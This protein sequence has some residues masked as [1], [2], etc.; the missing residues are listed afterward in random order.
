MGVFYLQSFEAANLAH[1]ILYTSSEWVIF[2]YLFFFILFFGLFAFFFFLLLFLFSL[3]L[4]FKS[5]SYFSILYSCMSSM[6]SLFLIIKLVSLFYIEKDPLTL[7]AVVSFASEYSFSSSGTK[8]F[9]VWVSK[10][11]FCISISKLGNSENVDPR[12]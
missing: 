10:L 2:C 3:T 4:F 12:S 11:A 7:Y 5:S 8:I 1:F 6:N 9:Y